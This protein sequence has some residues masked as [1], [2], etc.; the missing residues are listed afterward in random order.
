MI[1]YLIERIIYIYIYI[2]NNLKKVCIYILQLCKI[3]NK[4]AFEI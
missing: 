1:K 4:I 2:Y 3:R